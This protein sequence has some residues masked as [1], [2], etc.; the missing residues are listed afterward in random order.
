LGL[1]ETQ[2]FTAV[3]E[4]IDSACT[5]PH[6]SLQCQSG[7][8]GTGLLNGKLAE[9]EPAINN[10]MYSAP[11]QTWRLP[12]APSDQPQPFQLQLKMSLP[13]SVDHRLTAH[14]IP[15]PLLSAAVRPVSNRKPSH[16]GPLIAFSRA[17]LSHPATVR[18]YS[19]STNDWSDP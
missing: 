13:P 6:W 5:E 12:I 17:A 3:F 1:I 8:Q 16:V 14:F 2:G 11:W 15:Q 7:F 9:F 4:A 19:L 18:I 10:G